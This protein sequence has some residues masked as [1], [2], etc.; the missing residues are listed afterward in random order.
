METERAHY[1]PKMK[2]I[3]IH[4]NSNTYNILRHIKAFQVHM[5]KFGQCSIRGNKH[6]T[7]QLSKGKNQTSF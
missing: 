6:V 4:E 5:L 2:E 3:N 1:W 7:L